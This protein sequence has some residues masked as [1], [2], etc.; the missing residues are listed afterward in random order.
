MFTFCFHVKHRGETRPA[1]PS[2]M[3]EYYQPAR[4]T[5]RRRT[6]LTIQPRLHNPQDADA[7]IACFSSKIAYFLHNFVSLERFCAARFQ[8]RVECFENRDRASQR[9]RPKTK[10][11]HRSRERVAARLVAGR[12][13]ASASGSDILW[14]QLD[15]VLAAV[16]AP[17]VEATRGIR[18]DWFR[19]VGLARRMSPK[20]AKTKNPLPFAVVGEAATLVKA[21]E[22]GRRRRRRGSVAHDCGAGPRVTMNSVGIGSTGSKAGSKG[23]KGQQHPHLLLLSG[24]AG[25]QFPS[26]SPILRISGPHSSFIL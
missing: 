17:L 22:A 7:K 19:G 1:Q 9:D 20:G 10:S 14:E 23:G 4:A 5:V 8:P 18:P 11:L 13:R 26:A 25:E 16:A 12:S 15:A 2:V 3:N 6:P 21:L 24:F